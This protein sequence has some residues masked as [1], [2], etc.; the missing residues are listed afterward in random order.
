ML[1]S[2]D[3]S[4]KL[5][6][7]QCPAELLPWNRGQARHRKTGDEEGV[8][9][10]GSGESKNRTKGRVKE[11]SDFDRCLEKMLAKERGAEDQFDVVVTSSLQL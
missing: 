10:S 5:I 3:L 11:N 6:T 4:E 7:H 8:S 9:E 2:W 1:N